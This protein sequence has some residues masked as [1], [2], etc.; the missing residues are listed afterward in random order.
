MQQSLQL[1]K[2]GCVPQHA[3][4]G[5]VDIPQCCVFRQM[6]LRRPNKALLLMK[7]LSVGDLPSK[8]LDS[9]NSVFENKTV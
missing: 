3:E 4:S 1:R 9:R 8:L 5:H 6:S 2:R 7:H